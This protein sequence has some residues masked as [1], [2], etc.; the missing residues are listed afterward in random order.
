[1]CGIAGALNWKR[2]PSAS[3]MDA[4]LQRMRLRGPDDGGTWTEGPMMLGHRRLSIVDLTET[5]HQ[6]M[7]SHDGRHVM[8]FNGEVYNAPELRA[9][10]DKERPTVW[11]GHSDTEAILE[12]FA[13]WGQAVLPRLRGMFAFAVW[14]R[15]G[16]SLFAARDRMGVK[17]FYYM[18]RA[19]GIAFASRPR[20]LF[21]L[22]PDAS[23]EIDP[24]ALRYYLDAG[25]VPDP[26]G[27]QA[28]VRKLPPGHFLVADAAGVRVERYWDFRAIPVETAWETRSEADL[29][30]ELDGLVKDSVRMRL[31][32]DVPLGAFLSGGIDSSLVTAVMSA[33]GS[34]PVSTFSIGFDDPRFDES[35]HAQRVA[36]HLG[37]RHWLKTMRV[38]DLTALLP[39]F[40]QHY[41]EPLFDVS[42][43]PTMAVS[44]A[45]RSQVTVALTGDGGDELFG[46]YHYCRVAQRM[47]PFF[48]LPPLLRRG[49]S[50]LLKTIPHRQG[51]L[52]GQALARRDLAAA[53]GYARTMAKDLTAFIAPG[54][55]GG[56]DDLFSRAAASIPVSTGAELAMRL[57]AAITLPAD[58]L[59]KVDVASM[60]FSLECREPLLDHPLVEWAARLPL[61]WKLGGDG[62]GK[63]L[64]RRLAARYVPR[65][66]LERPKQG[67]GVPVG[68][69]LKG[70]LKQWALDRLGDPGLYRGLFID[71]DAA[72][73]LMDRLCRGDRTV[74][75]LLW[76]VVVLLGG[77]ETGK[78]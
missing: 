13:L 42:A 10:V 28:C 32:S 30:D 66:I 25:F 46:G 17:P 77:R 51:R 63:Y 39:V 18:D 40:F 9:A 31:I 38:D 3:A 47:A 75:P 62:S 4:A 72:L 26:L 44:Q 24:L 7:V 45:A 65:D 59:H 57:D 8:V 58:Y 36:G 61:K 43:F 35:A 33:V 52:L 29:L 6:P 56:I 69:W 60:A 27:F 15:H 21:D 64:L 71:R 11:R 70:P 37:T 50:H 67:F 68:Q 1:M 34:G 48:A 76:A 20:P 49:L 23:R 74:E 54:L 55:Q 19:D 2:A 22:C 14:D 16:Q 78:W 53:I 41:D 12:G 73:G 5:G